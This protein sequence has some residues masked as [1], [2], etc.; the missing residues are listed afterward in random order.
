MYA[1]QVGGT[2]PLGLYNK[3]VHTSQKGDPF[4]GNVQFLTRINLF[5]LLGKRQIFG[6]KYICTHFS[7]FFLSTKNK[8]VR[9][10]EQRTISREIFKKH[11]NEIWLASDKWH[12]RV[13]NEEEKLDY[14]Q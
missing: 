11:K 6:E 7:D 4:F 13:L 1:R 9:T 2:R 10:S 3:F 12:G 5:T 14:Y 8:F